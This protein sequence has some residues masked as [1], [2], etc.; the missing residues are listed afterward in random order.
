MTYSSLNILLREALVAHS[1]LIV[2]FIM[3][4]S[5]CHGTVCFL[6]EG[7]EREVIRLVLP[8]L[9]KMHS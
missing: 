5:E 1:L 6:R 2:L 8:H 3:K 7:K 9:R 4:M